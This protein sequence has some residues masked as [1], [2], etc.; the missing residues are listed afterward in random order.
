MFFRDIIGQTDIKHRIVDDVKRGRIA[1]A[2]LFSGSEGTGA[3]PM[4]IAFA[5]YLCCEHPGDDDACGICASCAKFNKLVHPDLHFVFP[6]IN[7]GKMPISDDFLPQWR[8][9]THATPYFNLSMWL[10]AM[11]AENQQALISVRESDVLLR[12]VSY[13][14]SQGGYKTIIV[15]LP[16]R[17]NVECANKLLKLL[18]EPPQQTVFLLVS[19]NAEQLLPTIQSRVQRWNFHAIPEN[20]ISQSISRRFGLTE[21]DAQHIA[22]QSAGNWLSALQLIHTSEDRACYLKSFMSM[23]RLAYQRKVREMKLWSEDV[24][25]W[26]RERQK[27]FLSYCQHMVRN[28]FM[29]NLQEPSV[30]YLN[31]EESEFSRRFSPFVN[32]RNVIGMMNELSYAQQHIEQN[33]NAKM[34]F[35]DFAL[36]MIVLLIQ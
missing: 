19:E 25:S 1:H 12:K 33:A 17:M 18:E 31:A 16:E 8:E 15:W 6:I 23:M 10:Q 9:L 5:R 11:N 4:A 30:V 34:V 2:Q 36:K 7:T 13:K 29:S 28:N 3:L 21:T 14:S 26:G 20:V 22:H 35:F 27:E 32:E 24:A